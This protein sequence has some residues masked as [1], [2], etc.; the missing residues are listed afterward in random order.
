MPDNDELK[1]RKLKKPKRKKPEEDSGLKRQSTTRYHGGGKQKRPVPSVPGSSDF[2]A[3]EKQQPVV[4]QEPVTTATPV[5]E[6]TGVIAVEADDGV[7]VPYLPTER[8]SVIDKIDEITSHIF[9]SAS[10]SLMKKIILETESTLEPEDK[11]EF[12]ET[13]SKNIS[14]INHLIDMVVYHWY[15]QEDFY[16]GLDEFLSLMFPGNLY[17]FAM[18]QYKDL[19]FEAA[20]ADE[21]T[22]QAMY[23]YGNIYKK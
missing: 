20:Y 12:Y 6:E 19:I 1:K 16:A 5:K 13:I 2:Q 18:S 11:Q 9:D 7:L 23:G 22:K 8:D 21:Q 4:Q 10:L 3:P 17:N 15:H 14:Y